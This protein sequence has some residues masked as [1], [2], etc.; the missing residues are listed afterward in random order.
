MGTN[1][2]LSE[3]RGAERMAA[4]T[5][6]RAALEVCQFPAISAGEARAAAEVRL[7]AGPEPEDRPGGE[8][9]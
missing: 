9:P 2:K 4:G 8:Q 3:S 5:A 6:K 7:I 1:A